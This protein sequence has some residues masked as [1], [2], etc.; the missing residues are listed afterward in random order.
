MGLRGS[1]RTMPVYELLM[2]I[3]QFQKSGLLRIYVQDDSME[4]GFENGFATYSS[5]SRENGT[6]GRLLMNKGVIT[7]EMH[8]RARKL[9]TDGSVAVAKGLLDLGLMP[10]EELRRYLRKKIEMELFDL[11]RETEGEFR[12]NP[13]E[14]PAI[15]LLPLR[16]NVSNL[17][18]RVMQQMD[19]NEAYDFDASGIH[20]QIP[21][22]Q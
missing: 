9:R 19:E 1:L 21:P 17:L 14:R 6:L 3:S 2:W 18:L 7:E 20:L 22:E 16:V 8:E 12:F 4:L 10:E 15:D 11:F 5:S 13:D